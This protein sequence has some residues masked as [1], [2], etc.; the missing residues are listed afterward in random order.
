MHWTTAGGIVLVAMTLAGCQQTFGKGGSMDRAL[1]KD[2]K[3]LLDVS[4][5]GQLY[6]K[7]CA[8]GRQD[9]ELCHWALANP[10]E[11]AVLMSEEEE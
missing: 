4:R 1:D 8:G 2:K 7:F 11:A 10:E 9:T 3:N 5:T 6:E